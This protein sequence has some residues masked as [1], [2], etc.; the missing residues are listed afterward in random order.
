MVM[1]KID[2][3]RVQLE[4]EL[5]KMG[6]VVVAFSGGIDS[7]VVLDTA[8]KTLGKD[9]VLAV[10]ANS[11]LF[12]DDEFEKAIHLANQLGATIRTIEIDYLSEEHVAH[13][14]PDSWY[15]AKKLFYNQL[16][17]I[18]DQLGYRF[19]I[20]GMIMDDLNDY[21]PGLRARDEAGAKSPLEMAKFYKSDVRHLAQQSHLE[22]WSKVPSCSVASRLSYGTTLTEALI[23]RVMLSEKY[24]RNLGFS[25]VRVRNHGDVARIEVP[26]SDIEALINQREQINHQ[27]KQ[28]GYDF[29]AMDL[30]GFVSGHMNEQLSHEQLAKF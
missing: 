23:N 10:I 26:Q 30:G 22:N 9:N 18:K 7:T 1:T 11:I 4:N 27:L 15:Y 2:S 28:Y 8:I 21:R 12:S 13:N 5:R 25:T 16:T 17:Q 14:T 6:K 3:K 20:D 24:L 29:V 19:V